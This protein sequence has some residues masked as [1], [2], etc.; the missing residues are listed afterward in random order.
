MFEITPIFLQNYVNDL[1]E[2]TTLR[3]STI[4]KLFD[5]LKVAFKR[6]VKLKVIK[7]NP[8]YFV[9]LLKIQK[10]EMSVWDIGEVNFFLS[11]VYNIKRPSQYLTAYLL[12]ILI[13]MRQGEI[14]GLRW[15]DID[16]ENKIIYIRQT[17]SH[18]GKEL[19]NAAKTKS[20]IRTIAIPDTLIKQLK[21][22][23]KKRIENKL[24][25]SNVYKDND[26]V[27]CTKHGRPVQPSNLNRGFKKGC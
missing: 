11:K 17:L 24:K 4:H 13:G 10:T 3:T 1:L 2:F 27:I 9:D 25:Y 8:A 14:L 7:E 18:D 12:A 6:A 26:L 16:F 19:R 15:R 23:R 5:V 20:S 21:I 22:E